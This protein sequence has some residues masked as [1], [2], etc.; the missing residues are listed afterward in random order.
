MSVPGLAECGCVC[1][2]FL[3]ASGRQTPHPS[4]QESRSS[5][6]VP[7]P[8]FFPLFS[9]LHNK[10]LRSA[11]F[12]SGSI[13]GV[14]EKVMNKQIPTPVDA[15]ILEG[16]WDAVGVG[17]HD[18]ISMLCSMLEGACRG[19]KSRVMRIGGAGGWEWVVLLDRLVG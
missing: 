2:L 6:G 15:H 9:Y 14:W 11:C 12:V 8:G 18:V 19:R 4:F 5:Q 7:A 16:D 3:F 13:L 10:Y 1:L 17:T